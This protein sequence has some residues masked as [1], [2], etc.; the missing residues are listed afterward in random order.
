MNFVSPES[1]EY[2]SLSQVHH[3]PI[4]AHTD[5]IGERT[6]LSITQE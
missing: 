1:I 4:H 5:T 6:N 3:K 2:H